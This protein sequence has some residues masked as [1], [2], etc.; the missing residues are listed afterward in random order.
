MPAGAQ[1]SNFSPLKHYIKLILI[2]ELRD[3]F[4]RDTSK[5]AFL[6]SKQQRSGYS[7]SRLFYGYTEIS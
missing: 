6:L 3:A 7:N 2:Q 1:D 5:G 4:A